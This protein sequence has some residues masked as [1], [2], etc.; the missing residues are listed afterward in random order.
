MQKQDH[1]FNKM[2]EIFSFLKLIATLGTQ[3]IH[4]GGK[5]QMLLLTK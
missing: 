4:E 3:P 5:C 1:T 2:E